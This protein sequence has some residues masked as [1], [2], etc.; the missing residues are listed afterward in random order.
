M[1]TGYIPPKRLDATDRRIL[2]LLQ[3]DSKISINALVAELGLT[4]TPIYERI[5]RLE[6]EGFIDRYVA[7][8]DK[9]KVQAGITVFCTVTMDQQKSEYFNQLRTSIESFPEVL[10]A[11]AIGGGHD[12]LLKII[13][14]DLDAYYAFT[15]RKLASLP[16][17]GNVT[18][19]FVLSEVKY[20]TAIPL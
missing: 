6:E 13:V 2:N 1:Q 16:H 3:R 12:F 8:V 5:R 19:S 14:D 17:I 4:K 10:E 20:T 11:Y 9:R 15:S 7:L 18:S